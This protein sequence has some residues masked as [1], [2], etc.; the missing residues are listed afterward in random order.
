[1]LYRDTETYASNMDSTSNN[2][3]WL[4]KYPHW[5]IKFKA[6]NCTDLYQATTFRSKQKAR[7]RVV[8]ECNFSVSADLTIMPRISVRRPYASAV[9]VI[10]SLFGDDEG[11]SLNDCRTE[12]V[13]RQCVGWSG[14]Y[15]SMK[16]ID[17]SMWTLMERQR[18][19]R[20]QRRVKVAILAW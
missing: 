19:R 9:V 11:E 7:K 5:H 16:E 6:V 4:S 2:R 13:N 10:M 14:Q 3:L 1:M 15:E 12:G 17:A 8:C 20:H 18:L